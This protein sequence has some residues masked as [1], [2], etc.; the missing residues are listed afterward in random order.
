MFLFLSDGQGVVEAIVE[1]EAEEEVER[2]RKERAEQ[3][4]ISG[5]VEAIVRQTSDTW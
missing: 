5:E 3:D 2:E 1:G 4:R